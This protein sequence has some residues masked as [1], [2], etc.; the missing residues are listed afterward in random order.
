WATVNMIGVGNSNISRV[1][2]KSLTFLL[3]YATK[4]IYSMNDTTEKTWTILEL[5]NWGK[6]FFEAKGV[7]SPR[8]T[9]ELMLAHTL[10]MPRIQ[11]YT[12]FDRPLS[13]TELAAMR[14]MVRRRT[15]REPLQYILG[16]AHFY[17][18]VLEISPNVLIP[19]PETETL[20]EYAIKTIREKFNLEKHIPEKPSNPDS[21]FHILDIGTGSGC[22][23]L[24]L[25]K[26][27]PSAHVQALDLSESAVTL[28][29]KN[30]HRLELE[31]ITITQA[32]IFSHNTLEALPISVFD[33]I[34]SNPPY[35]PSAE[36]AELQAEVRDYEP[37]TALTDAGDGLSFYRHF[38]EL[39]PKI[40]APNGFFAVEIGFGQSAEVVRLFQQSG[41]TTQLHNDLAG[42]PRVCAGW[43]AV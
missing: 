27:F 10:T 16:E 38:A 23:A 34:V 1:G 43:R 25:A 21:A 18:I 7:D 8:L 28:A 36:I 13:A 15:Q 4:P 19:R 26:A 24:S 17:D 31:N 14:G 39:F 5:I 12:A 35:I 29:R 9:I 3:I 22:I 11:L 2:D 33:V 32:D 30:A 20:V 6:G 37:H 41:F 40:L 42:I